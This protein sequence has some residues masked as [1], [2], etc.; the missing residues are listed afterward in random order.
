MWLFTS[1]SLS[2]SCPLCLTV[3]ILIS[4]FPRVSLFPQ[5]S[6]LYSPDNYWPFSSI[7]N[8]PESVN[9]YTKTVQFRMVFTETVYT[10]TTKIDSSD[11]ACICIHSNAYIYMHVIINKNETINLRV[12]TW[13]VLERVAGR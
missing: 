11:T 3:E 8:Q 7:L 10:Q 4:L 6:R 12:G 9:T 2:T 5:K 1:P 13:E